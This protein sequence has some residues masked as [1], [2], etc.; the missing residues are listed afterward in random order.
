MFDKD[1]YLTRGINEAVPL[2]IQLSFWHM[3]EEAR[4]NIQLDYLQIFRLS[5]INTGDI[6]IQKIIHEQERPPYKTD[7]VFPAFD[8]YSGKIYVIDD[9][10]HS[11]MLLPEEY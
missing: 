4:P 9:G 1:K 10:T 5:V 3:I 7:A 2:A 8:T 6:T 11:T